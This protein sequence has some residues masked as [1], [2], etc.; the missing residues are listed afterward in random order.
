LNPTYSPS[1]VEF[2]LGDTKPVLLVLPHISA[3]PSSHPDRKGALQALEAAKS[4]GVTAVEFWIDQ[5]GNVQLNVI[6]EGKQGRADGK[7][8]EEDPH[9][10]DVALV[11]HTSGTTG[12]PKSVPLTHH[13]LVTTTRNIVNTYW[14]VSI[15]PFSLITGSHNFDLDSSRSF[16]S[17]YAIIS[18]ARSSRWP[19]RPFALNRFNRH[20]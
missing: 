9:P 7:A 19:S 3:L 6:H 16:L 8:S 20:S 2:Y 15:L 13:N 17:R 11:L 1:E 14:L 18:C 10:D 4:T 12:R 5:Q